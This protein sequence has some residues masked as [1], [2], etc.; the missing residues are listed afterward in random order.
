MT[1]W[2]SLLLGRSARKRGVLGESSD[3]L[4]ESFRVERRESEIKIGERVT[5]LSRKYGGGFLVFFF[6]CSLALT[7]N[8]VAISWLHG[9]DFSF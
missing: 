7:Q 2:K 9:E 6:F 4:Q 3:P 5:V 8:H 1:V